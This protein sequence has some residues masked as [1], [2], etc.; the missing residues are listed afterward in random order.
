MSQ[1]SRPLIFLAI[2]V[3]IGLLSGCDKKTPDPIQTPN[4]KVAQ[5]T[6]QLNTENPIWQLA[7]QSLDLCISEAQALQ[8]NIEQLLANPS[9]DT[10][11]K[12]RQQWHKSHNHVQRLAPYFT[13]GTINPGLF[14]HLKRDY[15]QLEAWPIQPGYLDYFGDY[16]HSGLTNDITVQISADNLRQQHGFTDDGE[17]VLGLHPMAYLLWGADNNRP[18]EDF[19]QI[20]QLSPEQVA[21]GL[22]ISDLPSNRRRKLLALQAQ[23]LVEDLRGTKSGMLQ[24]ASEITEIYGNLKQSERSLMWRNSILF[25]LEHDILKRQIT[26]L[27]ESQN[28]AKRH[29]QYAGHNAITA[30]QNIA[31]VEKLLWVSTPENQY[32]LIDRLL[33]D[34]EQQATLRE[35]LQSSQQQLTEL[36]QLKTTAPAENI[37]KLRKELE[38]AIKLLTL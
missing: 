26:P 34:A 28:S 30:R 29:N 17:M 3:L 32:P 13:L 16:L 33:P 10:L 24:N 15:F 8:V 25:L 5:K 2:T 1:V 38:S 23:L 19:K 21:N 9:T 36:D 4:P 37:E 11:N 31:A 20:T 18:I 27:A 35:H 22:K 14:G 6:V 12:T 7:S